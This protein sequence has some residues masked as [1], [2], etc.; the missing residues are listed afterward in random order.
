VHAAVREAA[1]GPT[2]VVDGREQVGGGEHVAERKEH[3]LGAADVHEEVVDERDP[4]RGCS[5]SL[6][7]EG[8][9]PI[10]AGW[11]VIVPRPMRVGVDA[12]T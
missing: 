5:V 8:R 6:R 10:R 4:R 3:A 7:H 9:E 12:A 1:L 11:R 2:L